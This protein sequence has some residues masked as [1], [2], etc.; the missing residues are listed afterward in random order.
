MFMDDFSMPKIN[1]WLDQETLEITRACIEMRGL[2]SLQPD[3]AGSFNKFDKMKYCAA[4]RHP[5]GGRNSIP[6]RMM[7]HFFAINMTPPSM[8]SVKNI[9][10]SILEAILTEKKYPGEVGKDIISMRELLIDATITIWETVS[11]RL[12]PT[13]TKFHYEFNIRDLARVF[14]GIARVAQSYEYKV[15]VNSTQLKH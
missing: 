5:T 6:T 8:R 3:E 13:P 10:G 4:M 11:K 15:I 1:N 14:Q 2:Y 7:R 12:L 9:Y